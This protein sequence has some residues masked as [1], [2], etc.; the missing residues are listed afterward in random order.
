MAQY[1]EIPEIERFSSP[2]RAF[3]YEELGFK[4]RLTRK[5]L[6]ASY[7]CWMRVSRSYFSP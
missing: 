4:F 5:K 3:R 1:P 2:D 6:P 7:L